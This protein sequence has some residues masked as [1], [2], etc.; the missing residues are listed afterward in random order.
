MERLARYVLIAKA[1]EDAMGRLEGVR[2]RSVSPDV[3]R[4]FAAIGE[5]LWWT[6]ILEKTLE[7]PEFLGKAVY[8]KERDADE[9]G[10]LVNGLRFARNQIQ[11]DQSVAELLEVREEPGY[12]AAYG[13]FFGDWYWRCLKGNG[14]PGSRIY[15]RHIQGT[16]ARETLRRVRPF[17]ERMVREVEERIVSR[18]L[19][20]DMK[21]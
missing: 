14:D 2:P 5:A 4:A 3:E 19:E 20:D 9:Y 12:P 11:H 7:S 10:Y 17:F 18:V 13:G 21:G 16:V 6:V 8:R 15:R 1:Y